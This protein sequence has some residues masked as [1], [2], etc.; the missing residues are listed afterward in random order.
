MLTFVALCLV[1]RFG[2]SLNDIFIGRLARKHGRMEVAAFR[3]AS[4]D[5]SMA[6]WLLLVP[7]AAWSGLAAH[8]G[9][10]LLTVAVTALANDEFPVRRLAGTEE[11]PVGED[12]DEE[13]GLVAR[14][15]G[16]VAE[17]DGFTA[18]EGD[19]GERLFVL[20]G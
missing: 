3:C 8:A 4:L 11:L 5:V 6:P 18:D 19:G 10:L 15:D 7:A 13:C 12:I 20:P 2:Y 1:T 17:E 9:P 16:G 14:P